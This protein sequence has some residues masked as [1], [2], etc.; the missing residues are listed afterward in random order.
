MKLIALSNLSRSL[1]RPILAVLLTIG[2]TF[3]LTSCGLDNQVCSVE[4]PAE[5]LSAEDADRD[6]DNYYNALCQGQ[7]GYESVQKWDCN[8]GDE[9]VNPDAPEVCDARDNNCD[10]LIDNSEAY[11]DDGDGYLANITECREVY[12]A[13]SLDCDDKNADVN[14]SKFEAHDGIDNDCDGIADE[15]FD[16]DGDG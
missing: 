14:P 13:S 7:P 15:D 2:C 9:L 16:T 11:D 5:C 8:D 4:I 1:L 3:G 6:L 10:D 12:E